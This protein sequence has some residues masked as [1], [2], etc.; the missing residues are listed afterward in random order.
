LNGRFVV[1]IQRDWQAGFGRSATVDTNAGTNCRFATRWRPSEAAA[2][3]KA[4][5]SSAPHRAG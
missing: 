5:W 4:G 1:G 2:L 3:W